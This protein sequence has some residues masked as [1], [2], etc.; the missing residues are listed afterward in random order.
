VL[1]RPLQ[2]PDSDHVVLIYNSYQKAGGAHAGATV[3]DYIDRLRDM[4]VLEEQAL[5]N[6]RD[7]SLDANGTPERI[8][9]MQVTPSFFRLIRV[10]P[11]VGRGFTDEEGEIGKNLAVIL[12][13]GLW[14]R[15]FGGQDAINHTVRIDGQPYTVV[16]VMP[17]DFVFIDG[18]VQA[19]LPLVF[20]D[21]Q[22]T[23]RYSNNWAYLGRLRRDATL[24]QAQAQVDALNAANLERFPE[25]K[26][27]LAST[28]FHSVAT[29]LQDDLVRDVR[30][31]LYLLWAGALFVLLI[32]CVNV[33]NLVL[34]RSR[35]RLKEITM[36]MA[37]GAARWRIVRQ[38]VTEHIL[39][40]ISSAVGG[41]LIGHAVLR[42]FGKATLDDLPRG[43]EITI[44]DA[45][46]VYTLLTAAL[47]GLVLG[48]IPV[49]AGLPGNFM[50][51][52]REG[53]RGEIGGRGFRMM[54]RTLVVA[55]VAVAL[56]LLIGAGLLF[57]SFRRVL[58]V[59]PGFD[60][61]AVLTA[62]I[63]LP[64]TRYASDDEIRRFTGDALQGIRAI[65][66]VV[67][68][69]ATT[70]IPFG[71]D[72]TQD[73]M[74]PEGYRMAPGDSLVAMYYSVVT[75]G[76]FEAMRVPLING[77]FFDDRDTFNAPK[78]VIVDERLANRYWPG[79]NPVGRRMY[80]PT[81]PKDITAVTNRT[82]WFTV[83]AVVKEVRLRGFV[84]G[85]G[86]TG[87]Y[88]TV[89]A[90]TPGRGRA[91]TFAARTSVTP[92][93]IASA[94]RDQIARVD[95]DLPVFDVQTMTERASRSLATRRSPMM[96]S[97][98]F[99]GV[100]LF[101]SAVGIYGFATDSTII[102]PR[103]LLHGKGQSHEAHPS[104]PQQCRRRW[105]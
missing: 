79:L 49:L 10:P 83:I 3:P 90:Q 44:D 24:E 103:S 4:T 46:V 61:H 48:A 99:G 19:W 86:D 35:L 20:T 51:M 31:T 58:A 22:K 29:R 67:S 101:L 63:S 34:A 42:V 56:V 97:I 93:S 2:V 82:E 66:G 88:Y 28:G 25:T 30:P 76:Y 85:V 91:L 47:I 92:T 60:P 69:G 77:R 13:H 26:Q 104:G 23:Q 95:R 102:R 57:A 5:F 87:A 89:V 38:L 71:D 80:E 73:I 43:T 18:R 8:H 96:L 84:E 32:G 50:N 94:I 75:P 70:L 39:L 53:G 45:I 55:Q 59:D 54:R 68:A 98:A 40:T 7:P 36:R 15:L 27:V 78:A 12:S 21:R 52:L 14:K 81:D 100:A 17:A 41:L 74:L 64:P 11:R 37:L 62:S 9:A 72:F 33:A 1:L 105:R 65:P 16:G 6:T